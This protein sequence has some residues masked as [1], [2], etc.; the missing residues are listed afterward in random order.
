L[1]K[2]AWPAAFDD[3]DPDVR[4]RRTR[5]ALET[6]IE[7]IRPATLVY[8]LLLA[9]YLLLVLG[10]PTDLAATALAIGVQVVLAVSRALVYRRTARLR[11][12]A[13]DRWRRVVAAFSASVM[14]AWDAFMV[15]EVWSRRLDAN[16]MLLVT[17]SLVMRASGTYAASPDLYI[18]GLWSR[19]SRIPLLVA[20]VLLPTRDGVIMACVFLSHMLYAE[21]QSRQLNAEFWRRILA[22][23][24]LA[25][26]HAELRHEVAM[27]E[28]AEVELRLAQKLDSVGRLAA[29][30]AH[31][32]NTPLQATVGSLAF[33]DEGVGELLAITRAYQAA[34]PAPDPTLASELDYLALECLER[35]ASI[36]RSVKMFAHPNLVPKG[37]LD[38][39]EALATTLN[40]ARHECAEVADVV[41]DL[42][43]LPIIEGYAGEL[44]QAFLN[45]IVNAVHAMAA[46]GIRGTLGVT[47]RCEGGDIRIAISDTGVGIPEPIKDQ[48]F[49]PFFTTKEVGRGTGQGLA[50]A[51]AVITKRH[52]GE[53]TFESA[54][55]RG[56]TFTIRIPI[57]TAVDVPTR[58]AA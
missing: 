35:T 3:P 57:A 5:I 56:T 12:S 45:I 20:P 26:A 9:G 15:F 17:A 11:E 39:N 48:I 55:G 7:R 44:N 21:A 34:L 2:S 40:V 52:G 41:T 24:S 32:I 14:F 8:P 50:I 37:R 47:T 4:L 46:S 53:L 23:D 38:I 49:D 27:R 58:D 33:V 54:L 18:H 30:I 16:T 31:E 19:W 43:E 28:R 36:V 10:S 29:G 22:T 25:A 6:V 51:R 42:G 1:V 13:P